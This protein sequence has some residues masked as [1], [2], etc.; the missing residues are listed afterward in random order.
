MIVSTKKKINE[1]AFT[2]HAPGD[3]LDSAL[4]DFSLFIQQYSINLM[5]YNVISSSGDIIFVGTNLLSL[6]LPWSRYLSK[7]SSDPRFINLIK[8]V[9]KIMTPNLLCAVTGCLIT[10]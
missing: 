7:G 4:Q 1:K 10:C 6:S 3:I 9:D 5:S 2:V 8:K